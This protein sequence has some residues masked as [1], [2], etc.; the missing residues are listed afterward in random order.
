MWKYSLLVL[1]IFGLANFCGC[2]GVS[3]PPPLTAEEERE[4]ERQVQEVEAAEAA[5]FAQEAA[6]RER[7]GH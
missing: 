2:G 5:Q 7:D 1:A 4:L 6:E 3:T